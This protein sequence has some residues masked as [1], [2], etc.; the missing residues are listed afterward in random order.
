MRKHLTACPQRSQAIASAEQKKGNP[1]NLYH[2]RVQD[3]YSNQFW[4]DLE[5]RGSKSL[6]DVDNYL[7]GIWLECCS[8]MSEFLGSGGFSRQIGMTRK[9]NEVFTST[10]KLTHIY[11]F[12]TSS[13]TVLTCVAVRQGKPLTAKPIV[14]MARNEMPEY[15]CTQCGKPATH[16]CQECMIEE[17]TSGTLCDKHTRN[18][19]HDNYGK[20]VELVNS[21]RMGM[22]GYSG[23]A[24]PP[25]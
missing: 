5:V 10:E 19:P 4:L 24:E 15:S 17:G 7:R 16:L 23:P 13:E 2:V 6:K 14:L 11:D 20:P 18:H 25:Y 9:I 22:C 12:G 1:E 3:A 8:H 21:P